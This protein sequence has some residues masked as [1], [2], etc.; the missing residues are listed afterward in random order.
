MADKLELIKRNTE[1][2]IQEDELESLVKN[3]T[4]LRHYIGFEISGLIHLGTGLM[5]MRKV[6]DF[7]DAGIECHILL[8]DWHTWINDKLGGDMKIIQ[9]V[10]VG[11]FKEGLKASIKCLGG[12]PD[13]VKFVLGSDLYHNNDEYWATVIEV[14]KNI[15]LSRTLRSTSI[16]GRQEGENIDFAKLIYPPMQVADIFIQGLTIAHAGMDQRKAHVIMRDVALKLNISP[17]LDNKGNKI[18]PIAIHHHLLLGLQKP[19]IWP[20]SEE[21]IKEVWISAKMSKS[22]PESCI[23]IH[24]SADEIKRKINNAFCPEKEIGFNPILDWIKSLVFA[25]DGIVFSI[26]R[27]VEHGGNVSYES[28]GELEEDFANEAVHP[29]DLKVALTEFLVDL[30][31]P[32]RQEFGTVEGKKM[33]S[34]MAEL[35]I[36]R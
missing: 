13:K 22:K 14:S 17:V 8:A 31:A 12:D 19:A 18:K 9:E 36:T 35:S 11:Y 3:G 4:P 21:N 20:I 25:G 30:L 7:L 32:V 26:N 15:T 5:C 34:R 2:I 23:F 29:M 27:K 33:L 28:Y 10:A 24:D 6:V 16:M 1:E